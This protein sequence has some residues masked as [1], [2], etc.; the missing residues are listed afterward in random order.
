[1]GQLAFRRGQIRKGSMRS[2]Q[3]WALGREPRD[4]LLSLQVE[5]KFVCM[6]WSGKS[7]GEWFISEIWKISVGA[8]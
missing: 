1:M 4:S 8:N 2:M 5:S 3:S 7:Q 6:E